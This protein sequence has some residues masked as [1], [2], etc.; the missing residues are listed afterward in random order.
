M[1]SQKQKFLWPDLASAF[2]HA[3]DRN[4]ATVQDPVRRLR[5]FRNR[6]GHHHR[7]WSENPQ[8]RYDD[9]LAVTGFIDTG[10]SKFIDQ[11]S[12]VPMMLSR[13]P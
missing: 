11:H 5:E 1:V 3:P 2:P 10:L 13:Q 9:L 4:Q 12:R 8:D 6:I 7:I